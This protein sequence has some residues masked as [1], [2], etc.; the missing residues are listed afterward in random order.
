MGSVLFIAAP[1]FALFRDKLN[2]D[3]PLLTWVAAESADTNA[4]GFRVR[5]EH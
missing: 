1:V 3:G 2:P 4:A 5:K